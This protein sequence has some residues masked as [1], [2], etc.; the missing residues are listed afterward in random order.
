MISIQDLFL[1]LT[2]TS[3]NTEQT[4]SFMEGCSITIPSH[5]NQILLSGAIPTPEHF[6]NHYKETNSTSDLFHQV[7][8]LTLDDLLDVAKL[9][10]MY[11]EM[12]ET[13]QAHSHPFLIIASVPAAFTPLKNVLKEQLPDVIHAFLHH[14]GKEIASLIKAELKTMKKEFPVMIWIPSLE[15]LKNL[16]DLHNDKDYLS[17]LVAGF[18]ALS[19]KMEKNKELLILH[20]EGFSLSEQMENEF[21]HLYPNVYSVKS[22]EFTKEKELY[23]YKV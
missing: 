8:H 9:K 6:I 18:P 12:L 15:Q 11:Q 19:M 1:A 14:I 23:E 7:E 10:K 21:S 17:A 2:E 16:P 22:I 20:N 13:S 3:S 5:C 4:V